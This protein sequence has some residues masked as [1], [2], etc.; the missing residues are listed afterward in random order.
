[1]APMKK[2]QILEAGRNCWRIARADKAAF[3]IDGAAYFKSLHETLPR[4]K[5][6]I[7][8]LAWDLHSRLRLAPARDDGR[9]PEALGDFLNRIVKNRRGLHAYVLDWDF[10]LLV[11]MSRE[12]L[13]IYKLDWKTHRRLHFR[14]DD[15]AP[16]GASHHQKVVVID[17]RLAFAGGLDLTRGR[18]DTPEHRADDPRREAVDGTPLPIRPYHDVQMAVSGPAAG[19]LG[20][21]ARERWQRATGESLS[22]PE[23]ENDPWPERLHAD[24][25]MVDV[26][27]ARTLPPWEDQEG[28]REVEQ[29]YRDVIAAAEDYIYF[30][31][32]YF[33]SAAVVEA[34]LD[35]LAG[36]EG[37]EIIINLPVKTEGWLAEKSLDIMRVDL[38]KKLRANDKHDRLHFYYPYKPGLGDLPINL[39]AKIM[40]AD[41]CFA[42]VGSSNLNNRSMGLDTEC[43]LA[44]EANEDQREIRESIR[45]FR[46]RLL[47]EHLDVAPAKIDEAV[48]RH[49]GVAAAIEALRGEGR[50]LN[51]LEPT[52]PPASENAVQ[53]APIV[54]P[55]RPIDVELLLDEFVPA[56]ETKSAAKRVLG[57]AGVLGVLLGVAAAWRFTPLGEWLE[58]SNLVAAASAWQDSPYA[59]FLAITALIV[60]GLLMV[61]VTALIVAAVLLF[62]PV[63]GFL[64]ALAGT[65]T[66]AVAGYGVGASLGRDTVRR[67][68]GQR[69]NKV[70]RQLGRRGLLT[71]MVVRIV[72]VAPFTV[73][74][75]VAGASHIRFRD[76]LVGSFLGLTP[77]VLGIVLL[78]DR[79]KAT[80]QTPGWDTILTLVAV[81]AVVIVAGYFL[82]RALM[83]RADGA[84]EVAADEAD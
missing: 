30:E 82:S 65:V 20:D 13:P 37:P 55:E 63:L 83:D 7:L 56:E 76:F 66:S 14:M 73:V 75:L 2:N 62:G 42:R 15:H 72:P 81:A 59:P 78:T 47:G 51:L 67:M 40:I 49:G 19:A 31:N 45:D 26:A 77:G 46:N 80:V 16:L 58:V 64:Y 84:V 79:V 50:T 23:I 12:W 43:D 24:L 5:R 4:A 44:I 8:I 41:D 28:V 3:L 71:T 61:P 18:W 39:H 68:A 22:A 32:Q 35:S 70:S 34:L 10:S 52:L 48:A 69:L 54:D 6:Q 11:A 9:E 38:I 17:D 33:T 29:L 36:S 25:E 21:L 1:M 74:N 57:W 53:A 60:G 27:I